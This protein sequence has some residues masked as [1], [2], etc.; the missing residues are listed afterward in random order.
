M[1][2]FTPSIL[3]GLVIASGG[4]IG[5]LL[6]F[7]TSQFIYNRL[8]TNF[9]YGTL[10]VN[11]I[12]S[13]LMGFLY[14]LFIERL[15]LSTEWRSFLLIGLLGAFTTFSTFSIETLNL[16]FSGELV[17]AALNI[18]LSVLLCIIAAWVGV[19]IGRQL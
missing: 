9:P 3:Q 12:G 7:I 4:A 18:I 14:I 19:V 17:K 10:G 6:R 5:A 13:L 11:I 8:G 2:F 1:T 16:M 15:A